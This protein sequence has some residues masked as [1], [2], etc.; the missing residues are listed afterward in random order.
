MGQTAVL[1][2][3]YARIGWQNLVNFGILPLEFVDPT[4]YDRIDDEDTLLVSD[5]A[6]ALTQGKPILVRN[7]S[8]GAVYS[9]RCCVSLRQIDILLA[10]GAI[11][12]Y[13]MD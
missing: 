7:V 5:A 9:M 8:R 6:K 1:A 13:R 12:R 11:N 10:G 3:S 2:K 4:D